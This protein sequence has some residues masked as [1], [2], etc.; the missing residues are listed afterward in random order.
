MTNEKFT[1]LPFSVKLNKLLL[2][3][4]YIGSSKIKDKLSV[5]YLL[6]KCYYEILYTEDMN[7]IISIEEVKNDHLAYFCDFDIS[8]LL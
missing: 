5:L 3:A 4:E 6:D 7:H 8:N 1:F 2:E